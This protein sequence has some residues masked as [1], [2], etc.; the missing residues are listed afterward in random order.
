MKY[1]LSLILITFLLGCSIT[2]TKPPTPFI[3]ENEALPPIGCEELRERTPK[4]DC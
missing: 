4:A 1:F 3:I 2:P